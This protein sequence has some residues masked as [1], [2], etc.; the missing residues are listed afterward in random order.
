MLRPVITLLFVFTIICG[1]VYPVLVTGIAQALF[2]SQAEGSLLRDE[3]GNV[4]GSAL[5]GQSFSDPGYVWGRPS[6]TA[7]APYNA[8]ASTGSNLGNG[9]PALLD[10]VNARIEALQKADPG[11]KAPIPVDLVTAS[12]SGLDPHISVAAAEYQLPRI[13][14]ARGIKAEVLREVIARH[15]TPRFQGILGEPVVNVLEINSEL[16]RMQK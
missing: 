6:V 3:D 1:I 16:H 4:I 13:A 10:S 11:N 5:I 7:P 2:P 12:A 8:A 15:T 14:K 9:A